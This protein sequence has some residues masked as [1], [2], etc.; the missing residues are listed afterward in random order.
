[1]KSLEIFNRENR[2]WVASISINENKFSVQAIDQEIESKLDELIKKIISRSPRHIDTIKENEKIIEIM[3]NKEIEISE[4]NLS[5]L[6][7]ELNN[8]VPQYRFIL[9]ENNNYDKEKEKALDVVKNAKYFTQTQKDRINKMFIEVD[10]KE[11]PLLVS[12]VDA[13]E[14]LS[15]LI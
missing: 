4:E 7:K 3:E 2:K 1:M 15:K 14:R 9:V 8:W 5:L 11:I 12:D 10:K 13:L 6:E